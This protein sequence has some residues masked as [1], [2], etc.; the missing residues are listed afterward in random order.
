M[1]LSAGEY[2][3]G[4]ARICKNGA[5]G[6]NGCICKRAEK[7]RVSPE[8]SVPEKRAQKDPSEGG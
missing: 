4:A 8:K 7:K 2:S 6:E 3:I 1:S 5:A